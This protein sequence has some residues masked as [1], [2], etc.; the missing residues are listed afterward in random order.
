MNIYNQR[1]Q[2]KNQA[3]QPQPTEQRNKCGFSCFLLGKRQESR[4]QTLE[5]Q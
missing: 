5:L 2:S 3:R 4:S 1:R